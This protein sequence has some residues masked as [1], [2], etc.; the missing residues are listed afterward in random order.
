MKE[1]LFEKVRSILGDIK[2][3]VPSDKD[4]VEQFRIRYL[5]TKGILK[6]LFAEMRNIPQEARKEFGLL[7]NE[8]K[9]EAESIH[10]QLKQKFDEKD[11]PNKSE[12]DLTLPVQPDQGSLHPITIITNKI[13]DIFIKIGFSV[14]EGPEIE[15]DWHNFTA[16]NIPPNHPARDMQDTFFIRRDPDMVLR[17]HTSP[18]Q[19]RM[20]QKYPPPLRIISPGR[21]YRS[22]N[23][24]THSPVFH[25]V[26]GIYIDKTVSFADLKKTLFYFVERMFGKGIPVRFRPS[27]FP[28]TEP[29]AELDI[30]WKKI[31]GTDQWMEILG[32]GMVDP[33]VLENCKIN[34]DGYSGF[35][36]GIG[37]ERIA[38]LKYAISDIRLFYENDIRFLKQFASER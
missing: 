24:T 29:S 4:Q 3:F 10:Q 6:E 27:F 17:T 19:I 18:V 30:G 1:D 38:M 21:V 9:T 26:E 15:D 7:V 34:P 20:M 23:D 33:A 28:F 12:A 2:S 36:F 35:A 14:A 22:D 25:Q 31:D 13:S 11:T 37:V 8:V 16:L 5:G 32:C